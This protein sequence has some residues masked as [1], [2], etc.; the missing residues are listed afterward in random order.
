MNNKNTDGWPRYS[1]WVLVACAVVVTALV[2]RRELVSPSRSGSAEVATANDGQAAEP[3]DWRIEDVGH[4]QGPTDARVTIVE[5]IDFQCSFCGD[6]AKVLQRIRTN[7]Q[8]DV[9]VVFRHYPLAS[10][11]RAEEAAIA[12]ECAG[13]QEAFWRYHDALF[14]DQD[15][16]AHL[17]WSE[18]AIR[19]RVRDLD[20]FAQCMSGDSART[21]VLADVDLG[22]RLRI[23]GTPTFLIN[24]RMFSGALPEEFLITHIDALLDG[25]DG[26]DDVGSAQG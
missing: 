18:F 16:I 20:A 9:A 10:H 21:S 7:Y 2:A 4:R 11:S 6:F 15:E 3:I 23:R 5:F 19:A 13:D 14:A 12:S 25:D 17:P 22:R 26:L 24:G 8:D 1:V